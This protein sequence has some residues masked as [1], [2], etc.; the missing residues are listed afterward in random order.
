M[1]MIYNKVFK[2]PLWVVIK[3]GPKSKQIT[4]WF[5]EHGAKLIEW[6]SNSYKETLESYKKKGWAD[7]FS[8]PK[9]IIPPQLLIMSANEHAKQTLS[10]N[11]QLVFDVS[12][13]RLNRVIESGDDYSVLFNNILKWQPRIN[14]SQVFQIGELCHNEY[15]TRHSVLV[16]NEP[17]DKT[18]LTELA[19]KVITIGKGVDCEINIEKAEKDK[20]EDFLEAE[21]TNFI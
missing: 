18:I 17:C 8:G 15:T 1:A 20:L 19:L 16:T 12:I 21:I 7:V 13:G 10:P 2:A 11:A 9:V 6:P 5:T 4:N 3:K 14:L